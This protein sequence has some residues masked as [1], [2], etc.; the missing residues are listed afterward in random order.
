MAGDRATI[1]SVDVQFKQLVG[2]KIKLI[3]QQFSGR[4]LT[5]RVVSISDNSIVLDRSGASG[6][7]DQLINRQ[8]VT[9]QF[10]Y[11]G[12]YLSFSSTISIPREGKIQ[13]PVPE[14]VRPLVLRR[15]CRFNMNRD[16][17]LTYFDA[18][19]IRTSRLNKLR[20]LKTPTANLSGG[21]M[22]VEMPARLS[23]DDFMILN[24]DLDDIDIPDLIVG[25]IRHCFNTPD[26]G[27]LV[28][29]EFMMKENYRKVMPAVVA[30]N[31]K[32]GL[33]AF[34]EEKRK[35]LA[36]H[37]AGQYRHNSI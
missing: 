29:V 5:A 16:V 36:R 23:L 19:H 33:F 1:S 28:G 2:R 17:R 18:E 26:D 34:D 37:L 20:W 24:L 8:E 10:E 32:P 6:L 22:L 25:R 15:F 3:T 7:I 21:G 14:N 11:K 13:I 9:V 30:K 31:L 4:V 35:E 27:V 12:E